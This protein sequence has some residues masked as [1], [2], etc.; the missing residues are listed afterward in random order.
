[1]HS[2]TL[3]TVNMHSACIW[4]INQF[5]K[6]IKSFQPSWD[7]GTRERV[8]ETR[9]RPR[10]STS[11]SGWRHHVLCVPPANSFLIRI[12]MERCE[13]SQHHLAPYVLGPASLCLEEVACSWY[14]VSV[15]WNKNVVGRRD[16]FHI[17]LFRSWRTANTIRTDKLPTVQNW[18]KITTSTVNSTCTPKAWDNVWRLEYKSTKTI[19]RFCF[20]FARAQ[21]RKPWESH[22]YQ[23]CTENIVMWFKDLQPVINPPVSDSCCSLVGKML[24]VSVSADQ[25]LSNVYKSNATVSIDI[26]AK[27]GTWHVYDLTVWYAGWGTTRLQHV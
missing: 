21:K 14:R 13:R 1:M 2:F 10:W 22:N 11:T 12:I 27:R 9:L 7:C 16:F 18:L 3:S 23:L 5:V 19:V 17:H 6:L 20:F 24:A 26:S 25:M 8:S 15:D 4:F